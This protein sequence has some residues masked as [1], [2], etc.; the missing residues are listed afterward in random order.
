MVL[1]VT[2]GFTMNVVTGEFKR[3][4]VTRIVT[5]EDR[6]CACARRLFPC[7]AQFPTEKKNIA[8][9]NGRGA[10]K[11]NAFSARFSAGM[12]SWERIAEIATASGH[13]G[14]LESG[15]RSPDTT[16]VYDVDFTEEWMLVRSACPYE[17]EPGVTHYVLFRRRDLPMVSPRAFLR[18]VLGRAVED[19][20]VAWFENPHGSGAGRHY[21]VFVRAPTS[22]TQLSGDLD[23]VIDVHAQVAD[24]YSSWLLHVESIE[25]DSQSSRTFV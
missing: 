3:A 4:S 18:G 22:C 9:K 6:C 16:A 5:E 13:F 23:P 12:L 21:H 17:T 7:P 15:Y 20:N 8:R 11:K 1:T 25:R 14:S 24:S 10:Q 2:G 19:G